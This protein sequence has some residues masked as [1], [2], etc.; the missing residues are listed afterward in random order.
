MR[1]DSNGASSVA[2]HS[3]LLHPNIT[4]LSISLLTSIGS[5][6]RI[7]RDADAPNCWCREAAA[8]A[9][10]NQ[11]CSHGAAFEHWDNET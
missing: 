3:A 4:Q 11:E 2:T 7:E 5:R 1:T 8:Q 10:E 6:V 9:L